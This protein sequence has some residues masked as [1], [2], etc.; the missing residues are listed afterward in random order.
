[1]RVVLESTL[2]ASALYDPLRH[3]LEIAF[4]SGERYLYFRVPPQCYQQLLDA[5]SKGAFFNQR[6]RNHF[7]FQ[8]LSDPSAPVV[9]AAPIKTK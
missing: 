9:M 6:I 2:L 8:H 1:M 3:H 4:R 5:D 7:P